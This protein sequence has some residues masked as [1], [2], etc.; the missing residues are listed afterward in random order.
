MHELRFHR[1]LYAP[2]A[3]QAAARAFEQLASVTVE[4]NEHDTLVGLADLHPHFGDRL[5][6][7]FSNYVLRASV[8]AWR[9]QA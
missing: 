7:E 2:E 9:G 1:S 5:V 6:D 3:V 4:Q 8:Q